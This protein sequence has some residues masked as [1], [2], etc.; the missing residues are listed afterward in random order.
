MRFGWPMIALLTIL[1]VL[2][3]AI[4]VSSRVWM[5]ESHRELAQAEKEYNELLDKEHALK[6]ELIARTDI[7]TIER[8]ARQELSM[9]PMWPTQW[10]VV[11]P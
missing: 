4:T 10:R 1:L 6:I 2:T 9:Q 11:K 5:L 3:A 7:N 8:R